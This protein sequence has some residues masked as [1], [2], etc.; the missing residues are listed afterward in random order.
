MKELAA[1]AA[2]QRSRLNPHQPLSPVGFA[3][4]SDCR[5][6]TRKR[7]RG[8]SWSS[9]CR[10]VGVAR[11]SPG[12]RISRVFRNGSVPSFSAS[13][14]PKRPKM[15]PRQVPK[16]GHR[17]LGRAAD[18]NGSST[19]SRGRNGK[20]TELTRNDRVTSP[21]IR[22]RTA[23][24]FPGVL[25]SA[26]LTGAGPGGSSQ[27]CGASL[28]AR[29][30]TAHVARASDQRASF[31]GDQAFSRVARHCRD[32]APT[33]SPPRRASVFADQRGDVI[34]GFGET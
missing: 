14:R 25:L 10:L 17:R 20:P 34:P 22:H 27:P 29:P 31:I 2:L 21:P 12:V 11:S 9:I 4:S 30:L 28:P 32:S 7:A 26:L 5:W 24:D 8:K 23:C 13:D 33:G 3:Y 15:S 1:P 19:F 16:T 6:P 18:C